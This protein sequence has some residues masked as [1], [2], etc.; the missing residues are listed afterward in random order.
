VN[1]EERSGLFASGSAVVAAIGASSCCILPLFLGSLGGSAVVAA[2]ALES[3]RPYLLGASALL[4]GTGWYTVY[5]RRRAPSCEVPPSR[6]QRSVRPV[7]VASTLAVI[8]FA[9]F[10]V[11]APA[12]GGGDASVH[13]GVVAEGSSRLVLHVDG[14]TCAACAVEITNALR[15]VP[16]VVDAGVDYE[17]AKAWAVVQEDSAANRAELTAAVEGIGFGARLISNGE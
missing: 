4:I 17:A 11:Y 10:P 9:S 12:L 14:M 7:L 13:P 2:G 16:G 6:L 8:G 15:S 1:P 3:L 5:R